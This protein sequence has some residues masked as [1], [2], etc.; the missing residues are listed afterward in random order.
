MDSKWREGLAK[1]LEKFIIFVII[2]NA[3]TLGM[4]TSKYL[5]DRIGAALVLAD[6]IA[7]AIFTLEILLKLSV[8]KLSYFKDPWNVFDFVVVALS[9]VPEGNGLSVLRSLRVLRVFLLISAM[10][11]L[12]II[13]RS[14]LVSLPGIASISLLMGVLFYVAA[15]ISTR[16][17]GETFPDWFGTLGD[18]LFTLF[19][20][21]TLESWAMGIVRPVSQQFPFAWLFF[22]PFVLVSAFVIMNIFIA[23]IINGMTE[24]RKQMV[25]QYLDKNGKESSNIS[26]RQVV[27]NDEQ[28]EDIISRLQNL[29]KECGILIEKVYSLEKDRG[30]TE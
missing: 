12:R 9:Y 23:V 1:K 15:V 2:I 26:G 27:A 8:Q 28:L 13:V 3:I 30:S 17:F 20:I 18:S 6:N 24:A 7:L 10:P 19:Q 25:K 14:L 29:N 21:M 11:R 16:I 22:V 4:E 5:M